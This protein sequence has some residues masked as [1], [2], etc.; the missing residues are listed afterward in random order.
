M[1]TRRLLALFIHQRR[2]LVSRESVIACETI[3]SCF[4]DWM[5]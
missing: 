3:F 1:T 4:C 5:C 2:F